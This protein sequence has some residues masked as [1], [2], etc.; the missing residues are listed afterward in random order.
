MATSRGRI[1]AISVSQRKGTPKVNVPEADLEID[2]GIVGDAHAGST[3]R[4]ISLLAAESIDALRQRGLAGAPGDFAE[5]VT[6]EGLDLQAVHVGTRLRIGDRVE[7]EVTQIGKTC[8]G[9]C[10]VWARLG[11]CIMPNEGVF[12]R[13]TGAGR[14]RVGETIE[15]VHD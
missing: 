6:T 2:H 13:V 12:A 8:H 5:N 10:G 1:R 3:H 4:Q 11:E 9:R 7:L 15:V 14:I